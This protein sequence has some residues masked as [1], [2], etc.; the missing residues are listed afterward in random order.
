MNEFQK[1]ESDKLRKLL[2]NAVFDAYEGDV[3]T[4]ISEWVVCISTGVVRV[5]S[6]DSW[7]YAGYFDGMLFIAN[8][9]EVEY[10]CGDGKYYGKGETVNG[11]FK[12]FVGECFR[13]QSKG[14]TTEADAKRNAYYDD[15]IRTI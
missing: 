10:C 7:R 12:G 1:I 2:S 13:C 14:F 3:G 15:N 8:A 6:K 11:V 9:K 5:Y 4:D